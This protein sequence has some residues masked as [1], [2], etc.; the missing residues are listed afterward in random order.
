MEAIHR[1]DTLPSIS[2][3]LS[4]AVSLNPDALE[5]KLSRK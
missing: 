2:K 5:K 4:M 3:N 1:N